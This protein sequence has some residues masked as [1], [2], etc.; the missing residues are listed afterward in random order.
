MRRLFGAFRVEA[1]PAEKTA[2]QPIAAT[3]P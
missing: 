1:R 3:A 2:A